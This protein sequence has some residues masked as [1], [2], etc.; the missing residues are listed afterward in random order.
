MK[1][2]PDL[3]RQRFEKLLN[4]PGLFKRIALIFILFVLAVSLFGIII[5]S[6]VTAKF[7]PNVNL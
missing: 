6:V 3:G 1:Q 7:F 2:P 4:D 5:G